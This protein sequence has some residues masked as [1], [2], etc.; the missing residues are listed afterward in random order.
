MD[1]LGMMCNKLTIPNKIQ[2]QILIKR[3]LEVRIHK[4]VCKG[5]VANKA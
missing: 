5:S 4:T 2:V 1:D 3:N